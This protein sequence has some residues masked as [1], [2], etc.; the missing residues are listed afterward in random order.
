MSFKRPSVI[1]VEHLQYFRARYGPHEDVP[2]LPGGQAH[3]EP[4]GEEASHRGRGAAA[5]HR[6]IGQRG[7]LNQVPLGHQ[8]QAGQT[9]EGHRAVEPGDEG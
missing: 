2:P 8:L 4:G 9:E 7:W 3:G 6:V 1:S 5:P